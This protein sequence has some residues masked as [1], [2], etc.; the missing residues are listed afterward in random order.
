MDAPAGSGGGAGLALVDGLYLAVLSA[1]SSASAPFQRRGRV[2]VPAIPL[3]HVRSFLSGRVVNVATGDDA[4][5]GSGSGGEEDSSGGTTDTSSCIAS[6]PKHNAA[7]ATDDL[8]RLMVDLPV[9]RHSH[10]RHP[11]REGLVRAYVDC[12]DGMVVQHEQ[13]KRSNSSNS[14]N[15]SSSVAISLKRPRTSHTTTTLAGGEED[16]NAPLLRVR[17]AVGSLTADY[18]GVGGLDQILLI[19][20]SSLA[21]AVDDN[22]GDDDAVDHDATKGGAAARQALAGLVAGCAL[23]DGTSIVLPRSF[24]RGDDDDAARQHKMLRTSSDGTRTLRLPSMVDD[25]GTHW[26]EMA[27]VASKESST[28]TNTEAPSLTKQTTDKAMDEPDSSLE[29]GDK[30]P[31]QP[32]RAKLTRA[33]QS[34]LEAEERATKRRRVDQEVRREL[35]RRSRRVLEGLNA[36]GNHS[37][38]GKPAMIRMR[39]GT[40]PLLNHGGS[41]LG[42][43]SL[44]ISLNVCVD[45]VCIGGGGG[46][47]DGTRSKK[48]ADGLGGLHLSFS[49]AACQDLSSS[50]TVKSLS[51]TVPILEPGGCVSIRASVVI[52]SLSWVGGT[53]KKKVKSKNKNDPYEDDGFELSLNALWSDASATAG[54]G[55]GGKRGSVLGSL[56]LPREAMLLPSSLQGSHTSTVL[57]HEVD[58]SLQRHGSGSNSATKTLRPSAVF[59]YRDPR[60]I[61]IDITECNGSGDGAV[62]RLRDLV[63]SLNSS[64]MAVS[65]GRNRLELC[66]FPSRPGAGGGSAMSTVSQH[67]RIIVLAQSSEERI[68]LVRLVLKN[69]PDTAKIVGTTTGGEI[70]QVDEQKK[71]MKALLLSIKEEARLINAHRRSSPENMSLAMM[72]DLAAAQVNTDEVAS[73]VR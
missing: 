33:L 45:V 51:G 6:A 46:D 35:V 49:P 62:G 8:D 24:D 9:H 52:T 28:Y 21:S 34:R 44:G 13:A 59:E 58:W 26:L 12:R 60:V 4:V 3:R 16:S 71:I 41:G 22:N 1:A 54:K 67:P 42:G 25:P 30:Q 27:S 15:S 50:V 20:S 53:N 7:T 70:D 37:E 19:P 10:V 66:Y 23:T 36:P 29:A 11:T 72:G 48:A 38:C 68:G 63:D 73:R 5:I 57:T 17:D 47:G 2:V 32:W 64:I 14:S 61:T 39:Y 40:M 69:L 56:K 31:Q 43:S 18:I 65:G 55:I